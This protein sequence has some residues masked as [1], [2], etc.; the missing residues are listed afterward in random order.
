ML[1]RLFAAFPIIFSENTGKKLIS[2]TKYWLS[3]A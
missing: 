1:I 2:E 3:V